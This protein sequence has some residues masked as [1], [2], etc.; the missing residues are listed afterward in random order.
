PCLHQLL[1][2]SSCQL[3]SAQPPSFLHG[4]GGWEGVK[5]ALQHH[6]QFPGLQ[7][8]RWGWEPRGGGRT[9]GRKE[10]GRKEGRKG[11]ER[12]GR[13][14]GKSRN[15]G[16]KM[17][18][19]GRKRGGMKEEGR[20]EGKKE[21]RRREEE[22]RKRK[23]GKRK[24]ERKEE[25][26]RRKERGRE[27]GKKREEGRKEEGREEERRK[28][29]EGRKERGR[30]EGKKREGKKE[31]RGSKK[32]G[33]GTM[34]GKRRKKGSG[35]KGGREEER[36]PP[37]I[38]LR[39]NSAQGGHFHFPAVRPL[40]LPPPWSASL[41]LLSVDSIAHRGLFPSDDSGSQGGEQVSPPFQV[42]AGQ[43]GY[44]HI[45]RKGQTPE[46]G[47]WAAQRAFIALIVF[48]PCW[49][50]APLSE[51]R[52]RIYRDQRE[53]WLMMQRASSTPTPL[54]PSKRPFFIPDQWLSSLFFKAY[55]DGAAII[56][57]GKPFLYSCLDP[58]SVLVSHPFAS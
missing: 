53:V 8:L 4:G 15:E 19:R 3:L 57:G 7:A 24:E 47:G 25:E 52:L 21:G 48:T 49:Y 10:R 16:R 54:F 33:R 41:R 36:N 37:S 2:T 44:P 39:P 43:A 42:L 31:G 6:G 50:L 45:L 46:T 38:T 29:K 17:E 55:S 30:K 23:E 27:E 18:G 26:E 5:A 20:K 35:R 14:E 40:S 58:S 51:G 28:E 13:K 56:S 32:E 11:R 12:G 22:Q 9:E 1:G 34:E